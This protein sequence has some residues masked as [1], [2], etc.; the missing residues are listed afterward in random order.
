MD[1]ITYHNDAVNV[2]NCGG[3]PPE[4]ASN[5]IKLMLSGTE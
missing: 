2:L 3:Y 5:S 1:G 4:L